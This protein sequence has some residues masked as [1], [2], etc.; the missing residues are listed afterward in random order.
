MLSQEEAEQMREDLINILQQL[1]GVGEDFKEEEM[2][3]L[4]LLAKGMFWSEQ[5]DLSIRG[6]AAAIRIEF[7]S[8]YSEY[9]ALEGE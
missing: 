6:I 7:D 3:I 1:T 2:E 4:L 8:L 9:D 5:F